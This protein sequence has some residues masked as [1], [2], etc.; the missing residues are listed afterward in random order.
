VSPF[1]TSL[2]DR[3]LNEGP[4]TV[5]RYMALCIQHYYATRDPF[6]AAGDF[7]TAPEISQMFGELI[8][9]WNVE[10]WHAMDRPP[11]IRL[12]E[13][14]PGRGTLMADALRAARLAPDFLDALTI[15]LV[16]TSPVL[17]ERQQQALAG[18]DGRIAWRDRIEDVPEGPAIVIANEF[19]DALPIR[20]FVASERGWCERLVGLDGDALTFGLHPEPETALG[21]PGALAGAPGA[22]LEHPAAA[23]DF[24]SAL[25]VRL[26]EQGGVA[27]CVDYG[28]WGPSSG[29][30]LQAVKNHRFVDPLADPGDTDLTAHVDFHPLADAAAKAGLAVHGPVS[31][32]DF[33]LAL[34]IE[35]RAASLKRRATPA[36]SESIDRALA[37]LIGSGEQGMGELFKVL[38]LSHASLE[39]LP[40]LP[41]N[42]HPP[43]P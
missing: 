7:I 3:I 37:R 43:N 42:P 40:G 8:G 15:D 1:E 2:R 41:W 39:S 24:M 20:Q 6:G 29:D 18:F 34:G 33:L 13:L 36:Q 11:V 12:V 38:G 16:E 32:A 19:F 10:L 26:A 9:L 30:T 14:G 17:R 22:V 28:Y 23:I 35:P 31:Q 4:I 27:L 25:S 5:E 21:T